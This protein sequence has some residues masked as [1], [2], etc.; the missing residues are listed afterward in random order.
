MP[1]D[2]F[3][4]RKAG[5]SEKV[6]LLTDLEYRVWTQYIL[7]ADDFGVMRCSAVTV[8]AD[9]DHLSYR[10]AK[11]IERSL[12]ALVT[13]GLVR[14]FTHQK[15]RYLY[16]H[17]WQRFQKVAYPRAT[18]NPKPTAMEI[19]ACDEPTRRLFEMHPGG[20]GRT[21][22]ERS[23]N[24]PETDPEHSPL[25]R[26]GAPAK[27]LTANGERLMANGSEGG[28]GE[29]DPPMDA[30][31]HEVWTNYP[32]NR[33]TRSA[34]AQHCFVEQMHGYPEGPVAAW[35]LFRAN[36]ELNIASHEW[37]VK[38]MAKGM[39]AYICDGLWLNHHPAEAPIAERASKSKEPAGLP[40]VYT[41]WVCPHLEPCPDRMRC[42]VNTTLQR[43][44][45]SEAS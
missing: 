17:D 31:F 41:E 24:V 4:H 32:P 29:T 38:G 28:P 42:H 20:A 23:E 8:Q 37:R 30:W 13:S 34:R 33:R 21:R 6:N 16:Q 10:P 7:S 12:D 39:E 11:T 2:R 43:P 36:L 27:R 15:R 40:P 3:L 5:H 1:D 19:N 45:R 26:A 9:N 18:N 25:M 44:L 22:K 14:E 35:A